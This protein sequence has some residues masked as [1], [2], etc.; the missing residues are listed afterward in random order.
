MTVYVIHT[1][2]HRF[3]IDLLLLHS[4]HVPGK[5]FYGLLMKPADIF[6]CFIFVHLLN[7]VV[8]G[9]IC[10]FYVPTDF[11]TKEKALSGEKAAEKGLK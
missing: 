5:I 10:R 2:H 1:S 3:G 8:A 6:Y 4:P 9:G 7:I 11:D